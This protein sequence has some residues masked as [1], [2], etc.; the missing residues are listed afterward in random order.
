MIGPPIV[1]PNWFWVNGGGMF[2]APVS[3]SCFLL[4][5]SFELRILLRR[6]SYPEPCHVLVPDFVINMST[7]SGTNTWHG[8]GYEY[9]RNKILNSNEFFNKK[10]ELETGAKNIPPPFT[11]N[12]FGATIG[13]PIIKNKTF[14][15]FSYE[16]FRL[17]TGT[18]F[19]TTVP[20]LPERGGLFADLCTAGF[21]G[22]VVNGVSTCADTANG[23]NVHQLYD[24]LSVDLTTGL[25]TPIPNNDM[26]SEINPTSAYLLN[27][28]IAQPNLSGTNLNFSN[29]TSTAGDTD[30]YVGRRHPT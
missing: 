16:G 3:S 11:Q 30:A 28:L 7:K 18:V 15:F 6:Y 26:S 20:T 24:P 9:L 1:A 8:S 29:A 5:N 22:P 21:T 17:R 12:Q 10:Q 27:K 4:K 23:V 14:A 19:T 13:G 2:F 25:P